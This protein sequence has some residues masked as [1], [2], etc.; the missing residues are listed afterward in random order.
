MKKEEE[1]CP[2]CQKE[3]IV[4][5]CELC[6]CNACPKCSFICPKCNKSVCYN[7]E[8]CICDDECIIH[9]FQNGVCFYCKYRCEHKIDK[10]GFCTQCH[11]FISRKTS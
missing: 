3:D 1:I 10:Q 2:H 6:L 5:N 8:S 11:E 7:C 9:Q 4:I